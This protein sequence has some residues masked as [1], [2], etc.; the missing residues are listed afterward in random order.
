MKT[1]VLNVEESKL[2]AFL[3]FLKSL[4]Y[5]SIA[6]QENWLDE[7]S[8]I[9]KRLGDLKQGK[10]PIFLWDDVKDIAFHKG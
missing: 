1:L 3:G 4:D 5:V 2:D 9:E 10:E 7:K 6:D 8:L